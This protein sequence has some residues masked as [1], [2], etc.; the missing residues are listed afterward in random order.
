VM[1]A[2]AFVAAC[3]ADPAAVNGSEPSTSNAAPA[4]VSTVAQTTPVATAPARQPI[5]Q[6]VLIDELAVA[7]EAQ[8]VDVA[9]PTFS[10]PTTVDNPLHPTKVTESILLLG[11]VDDQAFRTEVTLLPETRIIEWDGQQ[12]EALVSQ[13][14]AFLDGRIHEVA[15]DFYAQADDGSVWYLGEDVFNFADGAI[16]DTHGTWIAGKDG[17]GAMIMPADPQ[18]GDAYRPENIPGLVFEEVTVAAVDQQVD[19]PLGPVEGALVV[20]ELH[21][22]GSTE[23]KTFVPGYGEFYTAAEGDVEALALAVPTD[24]V[25][26]PVPA[27]LALLSSGA[28]EVLG[29]IEDNRWEQAS[30]QVD[31]MVSAWERYAGGDVPVLIEPVMNQAIEVLVAEV[32]AKDA[33]AG[34]AA[35][36]VAHS[37]ADLQLRYR[38]VAEVDLARFD[39]WLS[40]LILDALAGD[41]SAVNGDLFA[42]DYLRDRIMDAVSGENATRV[43]AALEE[44][45]GAVS[46][47]DLSAAAT[48]AAELRSLMAGF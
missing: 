44:L 16:V 48:A 1:L 3:S 17:P 45:Q 30:A 31:E 9:M 28:L 33:A 10:D 19:G 29:A 43:N 26:G 14:V 8:R 6:P 42:L 2:T 40:Q 4:A 47:V 27:D 39:L 41:Q 7:P 11:T 12:I 32:E 34:Q 35:I 37:S 20:N 21:M 15:Y 18:V 23:D 13:Y 22:D 46:D 38:P 5:P 36:A 24:T 25:P